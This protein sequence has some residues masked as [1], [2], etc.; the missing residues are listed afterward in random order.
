VKEITDGLTQE[1]GAVPSFIETRAKVV[2]R[3]TSNLPVSYDELRA[4]FYVDERRSSSET[5]YRADI[6]ETGT[7]SMVC[8]YSASKDSA[9]PVAN[10]SKTSF[11][12]QPDEGDEYSLTSANSN[13]GLSSPSAKRKIIITLLKG[14][15]VAHGPFQVEVP[16]KS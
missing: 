16:P 4:E 3:N 10:K 8:D 11:T 5:C 15:A 7:P 2:V 13:F 12:L 9:P 14:G 1:G 6:F